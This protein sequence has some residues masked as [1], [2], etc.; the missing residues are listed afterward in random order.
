MSLFRKLYKYR[1]T[2]G[3][4]QLEN[5]LTELLAFV[6]LH[7]KDFRTKFLKLFTKDGIITDNISV[8]IKTQNPQQFGADIIVKAYM[9]DNPLWILHIE[10]KIGSDE[11]WNPKEKMPQL[12]TYDEVLKEEYTFKKKYLFFLTLK[13][14]EQGKRE[15]ASIFAHR[16]WHQ[17]YKELEGPNLDDFSITGQFKEYLKSIDFDK[18]HQFENIDNINYYGKDQYILDEVLKFAQKKRNSAFDKLLYNKQHSKAFEKKWNVY[19]EFSRA[20]KIGLHIGF[21]KKQFD[22]H[23]AHIYTFI[24]KG[25]LETTAWQEVTNQLR[26]KE[27]K[28]IGEDGNWFGKYWLLSGLS[29][30]QEDTISLKNWVETSIEELAAYST[31]FLT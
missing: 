5:Y 3:K 9:N 24:N 20:G 21:A 1:Q 23:E 16:R 8:N 17:V 10:N 25:E 27:W 11:N 19:A 6:L 13:P 15:F 29:K 12:D 26:V 18:S 28:E 7:D 30:T 31:L 2:E 14:W 4:N 22:I